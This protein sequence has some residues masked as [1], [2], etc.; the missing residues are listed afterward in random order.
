VVA[1]PKGGTHVMGFERSI[2]KVFNDQLRAAKVLRANEDNITKDDVTEGLT[3][4][5]AIRLAEPQFEGQTKEILGTPAASRIVGN[6]VAKELAA[7]FANPP[8]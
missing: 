1:T 5:V 4:V 2:V 3:A 6:V 7:W 8:R